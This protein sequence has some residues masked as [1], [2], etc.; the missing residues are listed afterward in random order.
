MFLNLERK[1]SLKVLIGKLEVNGKEICDQ[2]KINSEIISFFEE[3]FKYHMGKSFTNLS[4]ILNA[5]DLPFLTKELKD[6]QTVIKLLEKKDRDKILIKYWRPI[7]LLNTDLKT[8]FKSLSCK[9]K[10]C[11]S[12]S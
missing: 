4:N 8:F 9:T 3:A 6:I 12:V 5:T 10:I 7:S 11:T 1:R 2:A